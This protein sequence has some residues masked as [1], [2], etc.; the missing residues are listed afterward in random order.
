M[1]FTK[2]HGLGNDYLVIEPSE[3]KNMDLEDLAR[4]I[5]DR[6]Y[7]VGGDGILVGPYPSKTADAKLRIIN[8]DGSEAEKSG[9][10]IRI[11]SRYLFEKKHVDTPDFTIETKGGVVSSKVLQ[12]GNLIQVEMGV[13][14]FN[15]EEV[16]VEGPSREVIKEEISLLG[17]NYTFCAAS[18]G[19][20]HC[21]ILDSDPTKSLAEEIGPL[22]ENDRRFKNRTNVQLLRVLN[23]STIKIQIWERGA[24]YTLASGSSSTAAAAVAHKLGLCGR[25]VTVKMPGGELLIDFNADMMAIMTGPVEKI[26]EGI[27][28]F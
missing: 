16:G 25:S 21:V 23:N 3:C 2:Y 6:N 20:P 10:G 22:I 17:R 18:V 5:C 14:S 12:D 24:G 9:N 28:Y 1:K 7:G 15:S 26:A 4:S 13:V 19:N 27:F 8:P 11:F